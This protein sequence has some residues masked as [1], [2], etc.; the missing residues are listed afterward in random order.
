MGKEGAFG[1]IKSEGKPNDRRG[2]FFLPPLDPWQARCPALLLRKEQASDGASELTALLVT[3]TI[4]LRP[5]CPWLAAASL[6]HS[7]A[8]GLSFSSCPV[9]SGLGAPDLGH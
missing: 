8:L 2:V 5:E 4:S 7:P 9:K 1:V 3:F 6:R